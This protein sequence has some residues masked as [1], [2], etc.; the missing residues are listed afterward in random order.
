MKPLEHIEKNCGSVTRDV[1]YVYKIK[2]WIPFQEEP[3]GTVRSSVDSLFG[4]GK[5]KYFRIILLTLLMIGLL[6]INSYADRLYTW[7]DDKGVTHISEHPPPKNATLKFITD[8]TS[9]QEEQ[10]QADQVPQKKPKKIEQDKKKAEAGEVLEPE[11]YY[12][13]GSDTARYKLKERKEKLKKR[14]EDG[15]PDKTSEKAT[16]KHRSGKSKR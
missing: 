4:D 7:T 8:Y 11:V 3:H 9:R 15:S 1:Y 13:G 16:Q 6:A 5:M 10:N 2:C 12:E 14:K